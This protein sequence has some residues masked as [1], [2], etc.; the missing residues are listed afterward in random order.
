MLSPAE[1][2]SSVDP[3]GAGKAAIQS[4]STFKTSAARRDVVWQILPYRKGG[5]A[6]TGATRLEPLAPE[7]A[8]RLFEMMQQAQ[9]DAK[10][11]AL[12]DDGFVTELVDEDD[13]RERHLLRDLDVHA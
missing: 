6:M 8:N 13:P 7:R 2:F 4:R 9:A 12:D 1:C 10:A 11:L 5:T 3:A